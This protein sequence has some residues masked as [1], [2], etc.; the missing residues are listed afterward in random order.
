MDQSSD[1]VF[2]FLRIL[3]HTVVNRLDYMEGTGTDLRTPFRSAYSRR[4]QIRRSQK[5]SP[6]KRDSLMKHPTLTGR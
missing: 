1:F 4:I 2:L 3:F 5:L 6:R